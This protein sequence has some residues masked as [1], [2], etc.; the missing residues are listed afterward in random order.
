MLIMFV[1]ETNDIIASVS[2]D[3][4]PSLTTSKTQSHFTISCLVFFIADR[5]STA[6]RG[7]F[8][9]DFYG[10]ESPKPLGWG[11]MSLF[12]YGTMVDNL[13]S[14]KNRDWMEKKCQLSM[15]G[16]RHHMALQLGRKK[17][18]KGKNNPGQSNTAG[19]RCQP[20][21]L[22]FGVFLAPQGILLSPLTM[23]LK[24]IW[25]MKRKSDVSGYF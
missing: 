25:K 11:G 21:Q 6:Y 13:C 20:G 16:T 3:L 12:S 14:R 23:T 2:Q 1:S 9:S 24:R 7:G 17:T 5:Q 8:T 19:R 22:F 4:N 10:T 15:W 18:A